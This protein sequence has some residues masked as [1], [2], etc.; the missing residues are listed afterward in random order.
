MPG[1]LLFFFWRA[2]HK[3]KNPVAY[4]HLRKHRAEAAKT[5]NS[6]HS[7]RSFVGWPALLGSRLSVYHGTA[8]GKLLLSADA[9]ECWAVDPGSMS[10][11]TCPPDERP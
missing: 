5:Q 2:N 4:V 1:V 3:V 9:I 11:A 10:L 7:A 8:N 6:R